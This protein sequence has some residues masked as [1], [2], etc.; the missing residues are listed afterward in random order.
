MSFSTYTF[1][2]SMLKISRQ[3]KVVILFSDATQKIRNSIASF[4]IT[5]IVLGIVFSESDGEKRTPRRGLSLSLSCSV[6][7]HF[8][9]LQT[10]AMRI[11]PKRHLFVV[12]PEW[13]NCRDVRLSLSILN[14]F[15]NLS[16]TIHGFKSL[17]S[18]PPL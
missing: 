17:P 12:A 6:E 11:T 9:K 4:I 13:K 7:R 14:I 8:F 15:A 10:P 2:V 16:V 1:K 18:L 5:A 3:K